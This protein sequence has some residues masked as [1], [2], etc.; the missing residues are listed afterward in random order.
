MD[1]D[2]ARE[3]QTAGDNDTAPGTKTVG[4]VALYDDSQTLVRAAARVRDA[5]FRA[6][7][8]HTP[9]PVHG[10]D[11]AMGLKPSPIPLLALSAGFGGIAVAMG[12]QGWM[13]AIDYPIVIGGKPLFSWPAFV[14][15]TFELFVLFSALT[16]TALGVYFCRLFRWHSPLHDSGIMAEVTGNRFAIVINA[17]DERYAADDA[18]RLLEETGSTDIRELVENVEKDDSVL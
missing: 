11:G 18:R 14:P 3:N 10:L 5:G 9:Y 2:T 1:N 7:D 4:V 15:V 13:N 17:A 12:M 8:C 16:A 6:W